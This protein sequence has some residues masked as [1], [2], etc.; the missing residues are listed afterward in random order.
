MGDQPGRGR[1][2]AAARPRAATAP[3][4]PPP[5]NHA[6]IDGGFDFELFRIFG[7]ASFQRQATMR[8]HL[9]SFRQVNELLDSRQVAVIAALGGWLTRFSTAGPLAPACCGVPQVVAGVDT[10]L[11]LGTPSR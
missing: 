1:R 2:R 5:A 8:A 11:F 7:A 9:V 6:A 3:L 4:P 10:G